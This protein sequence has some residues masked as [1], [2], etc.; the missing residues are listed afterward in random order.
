MKTS[1]VAVITGGAQGIGR[2]IAERLVRDQLQVVI[3]D[4]DTDLA[5]HAAQ[6]LRELGAGEAFGV[7]LDVTDQVSVRTGIRRVGESVGPVTILVNNAGILSNTP[8]DQVGSPEWEAVLQ[9]NLW[10]PMLMSQAVMPGMLQQGWGRIVNIAS[11]AG[12]NGGVSVGPAYA[13]SKAGLIGLTRHLSSRTAEAG[14]TVN[15]V[16]P[17]TVET[18]LT[19]QFT[20]AQMEAIHSAIP[21][22]RLGQPYEVAAA[23]S[24]LV[25]DEAGFT[26]G[27]VL[28][29][30]GGMYVG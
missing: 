5:Q 15:A 20:P 6:E 14:V 25:S 3:A 12:R 22:R 8:Y 11:L 1:K 30:N 18:S 24:Y 10:G 28:D 21:A 19:E 27:A 26:T 2:A 7:G 23:V 16:C 9:V 13:A 17:G 4:L 29:M